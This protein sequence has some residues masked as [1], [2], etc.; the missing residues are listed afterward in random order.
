MRSIRNQRGGNMER[1]KRIE[2]SPPPWQGGVLPLYESRRTK[3]LHRR[4][5]IAWQPQ[6]DKSLQQKTR[7]RARIAGP[8]RSGFCAFNP[9]PKC[10]SL[11]RWE[12]F[13]GG[14]RT[15]PPD[16]GQYRPGRISPRRDN[17]PSPASAGACV[18]GPHETGWTCLPC[19]FSSECPRTIQSMAILGC[20]T[21]SKLRVSIFQH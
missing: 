7:A 21:S 1:D 17:K 10:E 15:A 12:T 11:S 20:R 9:L 14:R 19:F 13:S 5:F 4:E 8:H 3:D 6:A 16:L 2:L 18:G